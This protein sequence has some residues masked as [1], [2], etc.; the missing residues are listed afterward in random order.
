[1]KIEPARVRDNG[2]TTADQYPPLPDNDR[3]GPYHQQTIELLTRFAGIVLHFDCTKLV[4]L[5]TAPDR[6]ARNSF[7][8]AAELTAR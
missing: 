4:L 1:M 6:S 3:E 7:L 2:T 5:D 8:L